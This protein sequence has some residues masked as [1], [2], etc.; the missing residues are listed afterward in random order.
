MAQTLPLR[1]GVNI[2]H[3]ATL[4]NARGGALPDPVRAAL[5]AQKAGADGITAHLREDRRHIRDAD[6]DALMDALS[7]PL[8]FEMAATDEMQTIALRH[9]PHAVCLVPEKREE[10]TTE[11]GLNVAQ[12][13]NKLAHFIAPLREAGSRVSIFIAADKKQI[14]SAHRIGAEV[15]ELHTGA[16]CDAFA[17]GD[18]KTRDAELA[19]MTEMAAYA[20]DLGLEVHAGH[21]LTYEDVTPVAQLPQVQEVN[22]GHFII[23]EAVFRGLGPAIEEMRRILDLARP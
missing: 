4:R 22:I 2:D 10:R 18:M 19:A 1:L 6:I 9:K 13:E 14:D 8:N 7:I 15:I 11:G 23:G 16:Y 12:D 5:V 21:G 3:V 20:H 17:E